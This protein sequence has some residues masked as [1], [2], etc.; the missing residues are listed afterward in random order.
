[1]GLWLH[2]K[3]YHQGISEQASTENDICKYCDKKLSSRQSRWRHEK[4]CPIQNESEELKNKIQQIEKD[5]EK[6]K[7][8]PKINNITNK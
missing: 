8:E 7:T 2:N 4:T 3:K 5:V 6:L 1:M